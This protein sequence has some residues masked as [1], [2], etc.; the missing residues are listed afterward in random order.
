[1]TTTN[2]PCERLLSKNEWLCEECFAECFCDPTEYTSCPLQDLQLN[3]DLSM[4]ETYKEYHRMVITG[5]YDKE[6]T[7][8]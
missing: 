3:R 4:T 8:C 5:D 1:M 6:A 7:L 2:K